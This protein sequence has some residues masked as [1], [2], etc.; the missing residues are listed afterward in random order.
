MLLIGTS[1]FSSYEGAVEYYISQESDQEYV[2][3]LLE[4]KQIFIGKPPEEKN[5][6]I[7]LKEKE[8]R[9]FYKTIERKP[10]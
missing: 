3:Q 8:S 7:I 10:E 1:Y 9:Y 4:E 5:L 2:D 6:E